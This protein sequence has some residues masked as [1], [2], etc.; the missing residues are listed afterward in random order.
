[1][2]KNSNFNK[3]QIYNIVEELRAG[4][5][6]VSELSDNMNEYEDLVSG[7][8]QKLMEDTTNITDAIRQ[9][10]DQNVQFVMDQI[11]SI[12]K[13]SILIRKSS[14]NKIHILRKLA[15]GIKYSYKLDNDIHVI[16]P[17]LFKFHVVKYN[18]EDSSITIGPYK[19]NPSNPDEDDPTAKT[20]AFAISSDYEIGDTPGNYDYDLNYDGVNE[21]WEDWVQSMD[22]EI[23]KAR[24]IRAHL[25]LVNKSMAHIEKSILT[26]IQHFNLFPLEDLDNTNEEMH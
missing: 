8:R 4:Q 5:L 25:D 22:E 12:M 19:D 26:D 24:R 14:I 20:F 15:R 13:S 7:T 17:K 9:E 6:T 10:I 16:G 18:L 21:D 2:N 11:D 3:S 1:M 23:R